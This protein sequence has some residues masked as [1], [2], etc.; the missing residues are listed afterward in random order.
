V[1]L[2]LE[3][4]CPASPVSGGTPKVKIYAR[5]EDL[6]EKY[7]PF[8]A[9]S[10]KESFFL[11]FPWFQNLSATVLYP[12]D[13]V[14]VFSV[15]LGDTAE[16]PAAALLLRRQSSRSSFSLRKLTGLANYYT[17]LFAP[18]RSPSLYFPSHLSALTRAIA[19]DRPAW[20]A[21]DLPW[22]DRDAPVFIDLQ[23]AFREVGMVVQTYFCS[24]NW[25]LPVNGR[26][27]KEYFDGLRSSVRNIAKSKNK[28]IE[29]SGRVRVGIVSGTSG[30]DAALDAY[31]RIY[32]SSWKVPEPHAKFV[33]GF[34]RTSAEQGWLRLGVAYVDG[35]PAAAQIWIVS[36]GTAS[37]YKIAYD[38]RF[39]DLSVGSFLTLRMMEHALDVDRVREV[40]YLSGDDKYKQDWMSH[41]RERWGILAMNP[42]TVRGVLAIARHVGGRA[43]KRAVQSIVKRGAGLRKP[44]GTGASSA[45]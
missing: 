32:T 38:K 6:P 30:L 28:K 22:L 2:S 44:A 27:F 35:E 25:Y 45:S 1:Q 34:V 19:A 7:A 15:E 23:R 40:D 5:M 9:E 24:G 33:P 42:H 31:Q 18:L 12:G 11:S 29:R 3:P 37:I 43:V 16:T 21:V 13:E 14:R 41:R 10:A 36:H 26:T 8:F 4:I 17:S 39:A 20:D